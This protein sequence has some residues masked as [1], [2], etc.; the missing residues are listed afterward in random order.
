M[1]QICH[2]NYSFGCD[3]LA[4]VYLNPLR[5]YGNTL[6]VIVIFSNQIVIDCG[7]GKKKNIMIL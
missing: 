6:S 1:Y 5:F 4:K 3:F 7:L 2:N